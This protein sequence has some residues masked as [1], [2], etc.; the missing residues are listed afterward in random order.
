MYIPSS[1]PLQASHRGEKGWEV[2]A[3]G[4]AGLSEDKC[5][6]RGTPAHPPLLLTATSQGCGTLTRTMGKRLADPTSFKKKSPGKPRGSRGDKTK[7]LERHQSL[8][9]CRCHSWSLGRP[10]CLGATCP[11]QHAWLSTKNS[12]MKACEKANKQ[13]SP[14]EETKRDQNQVLS[15]RRQRLGVIRPGI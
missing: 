13:K 8:Q 12:I 14:S 7:T 3:K 11:T 2:G 9:Q 1:G 6:H 10:I 4:R 5:D 15:Q